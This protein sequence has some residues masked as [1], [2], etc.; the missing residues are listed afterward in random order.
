MDF[1]TAETILRSGEQALPA[2]P[3]RIGREGMGTEEKVKLAIGSSYVDVASAPRQRKPHGD[4]WSTHS[5]RRHEAQH[6]VTRTTGSP[7]LFGVPT[8]LV[9]HMYSK[10]AQ[11]SGISLARARRARTTT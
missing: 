1:A 11:G 7:H 8:A 9:V 5:Y 10:G 6:G 3:H 2:R 4:A